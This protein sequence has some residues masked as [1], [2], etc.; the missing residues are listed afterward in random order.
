MKKEDARRINNTSANKNM[1]IE[2]DLWLKFVDNNQQPVLI[3]TAISKGR[4]DDSIY[5]LYYAPSDISKT[6]P[7]K[8][9]YS[10]GSE[11]DTARFETISSAKYYLKKSDYSAKW[12]KAKY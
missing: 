8:L 9:D 1:N 5:K 12:Q 11:F 4:F 7:F 6:N 10:C 3:G 2:I